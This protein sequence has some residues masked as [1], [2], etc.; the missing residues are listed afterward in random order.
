M[1]IPRS[2]PDSLHRPLAALV[3]QHPSTT[4]RLAVGHDPPTGKLGTGP[5][6]NLLHRLRL[7]EVAHSRHHRLE[8]QGRESARAGR[9]AR[10]PAPA[11]RPTRG[12]VPG[13][14]AVASDAASIGRSRHIA[15]RAN[16][17]Q[18]M[19]ES[20][21]IEPRHLPGEDTC[22]DALT[23]PLD[24]KRFVRLREYLMNS[25]VAGNAAAG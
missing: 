25:R 10:R 11:A 9:W 12:R 1:C 15:R 6:L 3:P 21:E 2:V 18:D 22:A 20:G 17:L 13:A 4:G 16:F 19:H 7:V 5:I 8:R 23:K 14:V 24:K